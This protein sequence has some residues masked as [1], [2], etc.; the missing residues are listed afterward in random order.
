MSAGGELSDQ[1]DR[2]PNYLT[3]L[4][5]PFAIELDRRTL[6]DLFHLQGRVPFDF[7]SPMSSA[8]LHGYLARG[9]VGRVDAQPVLAVDFDAS[10]PMAGPIPGHG[11]MSIGGTMRMQG[12][13]YYAL[14]GDA[15]LL[16]LD[17]KM[18]ISGLLRGPGESSPVT[19]IYQRAIK[20]DDSA[21]SM[22]EANSK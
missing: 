19:I 3:V 16:A 14:R 12:T 6:H 22:T 8:T 5:Q 20:A 11:A 13:A 15:L 17:E 2:D 1:A 9:P 21:P 18:S 10:G 7:P 4:N